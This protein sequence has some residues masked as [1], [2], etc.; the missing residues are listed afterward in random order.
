MARFGQKDLQN[1]IKN[2][3]KKKKFWIYM[4]SSN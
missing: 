2:L 3:K 4:I 1:V